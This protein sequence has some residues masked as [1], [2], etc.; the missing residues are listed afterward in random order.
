MISRTLLRME[1]RYLTGKERSDLQGY[2]TTAR[3]RRSALDEARRSSVQIADNVITNM[4]RRYPQF[5][6]HRPQGFDKGH[7]DLVLLTHM[8]ANAMFLGETD[9]IDDMFTYW[10][11][12]ILKG[13]H[14]TPQFMNDTF[15]LW[16]EG[17]EKTFTETTYDLMRPVAEHMASML[18][19]LPASGKDEIGERR[20][21][22]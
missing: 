1:N 22:V 12:S 4:R 16:L 8:T 18:S 20:A 7:R 11:K 21:A 10:Y 19:D 9:T 17:M 15:T 14:L 6:Q 3:T 2:L 5:A 13:V